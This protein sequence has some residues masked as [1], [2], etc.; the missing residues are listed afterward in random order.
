L[1]VAALTVAAFLLIT[2]NSRLNN[3]MTVICS[4]FHP[5]IFKIVTGLLGQ[6]VL[7]CEPK[8]NRDGPRRHHRD[9]KL[10]ADGRR[11]RDAGSVGN[12][13]YSGMTFV[14][15]AASLKRLIFGDATFGL[16]NFERYFDKRTVASEAR[17]ATI[18][19]CPRRI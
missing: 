18:V 3:L 6:K 8:R 5:V 2:T 19:F 17:L 4:S 15:D 10:D 14:E 13:S 12:N 1:S 7:R 11:R 16:S 9:G